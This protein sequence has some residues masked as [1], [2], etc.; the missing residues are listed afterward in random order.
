MLEGDSATG[1][2][3]KS[4][5]FI[6]T[7]TVAQA[8]APAQALTVALTHTVTLLRGASLCHIWTIKV[9]WYYELDHG[10]RLPQG[11]K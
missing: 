5:S 1:T 8:L 11:Y 9:T 3:R 2:P 10:L 7:L 4:H 6:L